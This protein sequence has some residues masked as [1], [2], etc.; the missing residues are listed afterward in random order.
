VAYDT[1]P[2]WHYFPSVPEILVTF[3][4]VCLEVLIYIA[5]VRKFPILP[6]SPIT[7]VR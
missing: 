2:G 7:S 1:G 4:L 6:G 3:G 5:L